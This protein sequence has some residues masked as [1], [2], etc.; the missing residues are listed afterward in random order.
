[1]APDQIFIELRVLGVVWEEDGVWIAGFPRLE[2][3]SQGSSQDE[4]KN[5]AREALRLWVR[6]CLD[7][8]TL[9]A[10]LREL[11]WHAFSEG[12]SD[13]QGG[14]S[15]SVTVYSVEQKGEAWEGHVAIP[16]YQASALMNASP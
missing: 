13:P 12:D 7:R 15:E 10:A 9:D 4:A 2:V 8:N 6:S 16:A 3:F 5:E 1:M 11:G 14:A